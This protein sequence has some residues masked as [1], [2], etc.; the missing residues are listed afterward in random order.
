MGIKTI[1]V[2]LDQ[3][4]QAA[5]RVAAAAALARR[6]EA[7]L[8][9]L[10]PTGWVMMPAD[11]TGTLGAAEY[12]ETMMKL[13]REAAHESVRRFNAQADRLGVASY[14]GRMEASDVANSMVLAAH[15][16][17]LTV[18]T[19][20]EP[21][22]WVTT[23]SP[24]M[25][26]EVLLHSGRPLLV[27]PYAGECTIPEDASVLVGWNASREAAR[28]MHDA[29]PFLKRAAKVQ[30]VVFDAPEDVDRRHGDLPGA[31][32]GLW[33]ARHDVKVEVAHVPTKVAVGE[34]LLSHAADV[35]ADLIVAGGYGHSRFRETILGGV[36][37]TLL[38]SSPV[39]V[40]L[41]H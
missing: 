12:E 19:Q 17:D 36:T 35:S 38:R 20:T 27:L 23:Q 39:P 21:N 24:Q 6:Y 10:A 26:Q 9:G 5:A 11:C 7:H 22:E 4:E 28:A 3:R 33:L 18:V 30:I 31:D 41:S 14:E 25:P 34:A 32:I 16:C 29:L 2:H 15:Y 1:L 37:R 13:L 40:L 8:I